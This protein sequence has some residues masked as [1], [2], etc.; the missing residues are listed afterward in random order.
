MLTPAM[1]RLVP[2]PLVLVQLPPSAAVLTVEASAAG[3]TV[4]AAPMQPN[5]WLMLTEPPPAQV[6]PVPRPNWL[7]RAV[8]VPE[9][10]SKSAFSE[11]MPNCQMPV[12][13]LT[14]S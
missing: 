1:V 6:D 4:R 14:G 12:T 3:P 13:Q 11:Q 5:H 7:L 9:L 10:G 8:R 2:A